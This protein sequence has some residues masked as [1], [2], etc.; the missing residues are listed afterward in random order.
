ATAARPTALA[1]LPGTNTM[2]LTFH[3]TRPAA[4]TP[5][6]AVAAPAKPAPPPAADATR[7]LLVGTWGHQTDSVIVKLTLNADGTFSTVRDYKR[8]L[9]KLFDAEDR[10]SGT[11]RFTDGVLSLT[12]SGSSDRSNIGQVSSYQI[13]S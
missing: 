7:Q 1:S 8:G 10:S 9:K 3:L 6:P 13:T 2:L 11:W 5:A 12:T 4:G